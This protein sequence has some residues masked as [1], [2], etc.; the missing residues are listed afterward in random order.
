MALIVTFRTKIY[1]VSHFWRE[2][3]NIWTIEEWYK[4]EWIQFLDWHIFGDFSTLWTIFLNCKTIS[5]LFF[6]VFPTER[7]CSVSAIYELFPKCPFLLLLLPREKMRRT[8]VRSF[9]FRSFGSYSKQR[10]WYLRLLTFSP[11]RVLRAGVKGNIYL[12]SRPRQIFAINLRS[13]V[14]IARKKRQILRHM[15][16]P[17]HLNRRSKI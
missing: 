9:S 16:S 14:T 6:S 8:F 1:N 5:D 3:S 10:W 12:V 13:H 17:M 2:N 11:L 4:T 7:Q 15:M